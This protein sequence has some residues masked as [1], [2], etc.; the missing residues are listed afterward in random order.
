M[1]V[2]FENAQKKRLE[3]PD[4]FS[5]PTKEE[6]DA[7]RPGSIVKVCTEG[8]RFWAVVT[9]VNGNHIEARIDN[10]LLLVEQHGLNYRDLIKFQ[11]CHIYSIIK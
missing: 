9:E 6:L 4:T 11:K 3:N 10:D 8:E 7:I 5:A 2:I 1:K